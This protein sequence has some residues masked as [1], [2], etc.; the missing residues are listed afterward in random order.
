[1]DYDCYGSSISVWFRTV[2]KMSLICLTGTQLLSTVAVAEA[3]PDISVAMDYVQLTPSQR[4]FLVILSPLT[5]DLF[6]IANSVKAHSTH[7]SS[8]KYVKFTRLK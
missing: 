3:T 1:M 6:I 5:Q 8:L 7:P 2:F 4:R